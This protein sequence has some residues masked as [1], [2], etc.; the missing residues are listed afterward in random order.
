MPD[1]MLV[2]PTAD[3]L[4]IAFLV[5]PTVWL[6]LHVKWWIRERRRSGIAK[7]HCDTQTWFIK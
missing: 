7:A 5:G 6:F 1:L 3:L 2:E 4:L